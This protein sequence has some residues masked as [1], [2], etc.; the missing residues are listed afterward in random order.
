[1]LVPGATF[2]QVIALGSATVSNGGT[3]SAQFGTTLSSGTVYLA[4]TVRINDLGTPLNTVNSFGGVTLKSGDFEFGQPWQQTSWGMGD[5]STAGFPNSISP[6][7]PIASGVGVNAVLKYGFSGGEWSFRGT[8]FNPDLTKSET[9]NQSVFTGLTKS[10]GSSPLSA[11][12][13]RSG[14]SNT[15]YFTDT[16]VYY[17]AAT[18]FS[19]VPEPSTYAAIIGVF[20]LGFAAYKRRVAVKD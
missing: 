9:D 13:F 1:M 2:A 15:Y 14:S 20:A 19:A 11:V 18:P 6:N 10:L 12:F 17:G 16:E 7:A 8:Y 3:A 4:V 5:S